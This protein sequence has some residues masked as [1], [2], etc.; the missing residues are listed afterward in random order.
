VIEGEQAFED[1]G[2]AESG[3][4]AVGGEDGFVEFAM[5]VG[6]P[7]RPLVVEVREGAI[8]ALQFAGT[9]R[10]QPGIALLDQLLGGFGDPPARPPCKGLCR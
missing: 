7:S 8:L 3:W 1:F 9:G 2:I 6:Q 4:P 5:G 10:I